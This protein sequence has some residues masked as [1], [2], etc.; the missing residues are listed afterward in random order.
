MLARLRRFLGWQ[1]AAGVEDE[2]RELA[3]TS[4]DPFSVSPYY[5]VAEAH[6]DELWESLIWPRIRHLDFS[7]TLDLATGHGRN[8][9][10]LRQVADQL[11]LV[12]IN[13][14]CLKACRKR[15]GKDAGFRYVRTNGYDL[16]SIESEH[17]SL[18]YSFDAMVH[19]AP[20]VVA[21]YLPEIHRI[22]E[23]GGH[24]FLHHSNY[25]ERPDGDFRESPHWRNYMSLELFAEMAGDAGL[26]VVSSEA[27]DWGQPDDRVTDLDGLTLLRRAA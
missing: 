13:D 27:I 25:A 23:P 16:A 20:A 9:A 10:K 2:L 26:E 17:V 5:E 11:I 15:F 21:S 1:P 18:V 12:D 19:F 4:G 3:R 22:L 8:A 24:A 6:M 7:R 14:E